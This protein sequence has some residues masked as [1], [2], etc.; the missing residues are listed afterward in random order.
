M[1]TQTPLISQAEIAG[2]ID[3]W[4]LAGVEVDAL[5]E[6]SGWLDDETKPAPADATTAPTPPPPP[7]PEAPPPRPIG[8]DIEGLAKVPG[9][10]P[11]W[12]G[13]LAAFQCWWTEDENFAPTGAFPRIAPRGAANAPLMV[14]VGHPEEA[15]AERLLSG[16][17][18]VLLSGFLRAAGIA[19][20]QV[21]LASALP[22]HTLR[23]DWSEVAAAGYGKL[24]A[25]HIGLVGPERLIAFGRDILALIPHESA[26]EP[27]SLR[28]FNHDGRSIPLL[29]ARDLANLARRGG[30]RSQFWRQWLDFTDG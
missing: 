3:W 10:A 23:P 8:A 1:G 4:R 18:G 11:E 22:R 5:D 26:Q 2:A 28:V 6:A 17:Q 29:P 16:P 14:V 27:A 25:H 9:E 30:F 12:P 7:K 24:L 21:Y 15:D 19:E 13:E 20:D